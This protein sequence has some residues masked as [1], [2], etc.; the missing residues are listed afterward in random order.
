A[1]FAFTRGMT[2]GPDPRVASATGGDALASFLLGTGTS[3]S[4]THR[5]KPANISR[6]YA[7]YAQDDFKMSSKLTLNVGLRWEMEGA[8]TERYDQQTA[9][10]PYIRNPL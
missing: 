7:L 4:S 9:M 8:A 6:Y 10:D 1:H 2:Q 3:G 5:I